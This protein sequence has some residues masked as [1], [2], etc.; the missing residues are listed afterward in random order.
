MQMMLL[1]LMLGGSLGGGNDAVPPQP[2][3]TDA[4]VP[5]ARAVRLLIRL[6]D[7]GADADGA[8][9]QARL[10]RLMADVGAPPGA[11]LHWMRAQAAGGEL[12]RLE[13]V[14]PAELEP[15]LSRLRAQ[16]GVI[17]LEHDGRNTIDPGPVL[18]QS[19]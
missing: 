19:L 6:E 18:R 15:L 2:A 4:T 1:T 8:Q 13:G 14:A 16:P 12:A 10:D 17:W 11:R 9:R 7:L 3:P 5:A